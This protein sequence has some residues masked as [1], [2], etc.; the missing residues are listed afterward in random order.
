[1]NNASFTFINWPLTLPSKSIE[2]GYPTHYEAYYE[3]VPYEDLSRLKTSHRKTLFM[4]L[5]SGAV[6]AVKLNKKKNGVKANNINGNVNSNINNKPN[7]NSLIANSVPVRNNNYFVDEYKKTEKDIENI[8]KRRNE[9]SLEKQHSPSFIPVNERFR[10]D[11]MDR[12][13][14]PRNDPNYPYRYSDKPN[15]YDYKDPIIEK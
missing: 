10:E 4:A 9:I 5:R 11:D 15:S 14:G 2:P 7:S 1:M 12:S 13:K 6:Y 3:E 8:E